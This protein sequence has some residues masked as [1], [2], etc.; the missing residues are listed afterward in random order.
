M[1]LKYGH[2]FVNFSFFLV[3]FW[4]LQHKVRPVGNGNTVPGS[5]VHIQA[6]SVAP[7]YQPFPLYIIP[8]KGKQ[9]VLKEQK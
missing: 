5:R 2:D 8:G 6:A 4:V 9:N 1:L 7:L 3:L